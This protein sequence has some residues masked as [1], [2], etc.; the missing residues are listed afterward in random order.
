MNFIFKSKGILF[1]GEN[2]N[3]YIYIWFLVGY[4]NIFFLFKIKEYWYFVVILMIVFV[5]Y[6]IG[7]RDIMLIL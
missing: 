6:F 5:N 7:W 3:I 2:N 4:E 1:L